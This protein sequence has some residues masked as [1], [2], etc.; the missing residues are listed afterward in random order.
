[1]CLFR[2]GSLLACMQDFVFFTVFFHD[3]KSFAAEQLWISFDLQCTWKTPSCGD[4]FICD[5]LVREESQCPFLSSPAAQLPSWSYLLLSVYSSIGSP[6]SAILQ[7]TYNWHSHARFGAPDPCKG[8][9]ILLRMWFLTSKPIHPSTRLTA[10]QVFWQPSE[11]SQANL[12][13]AHHNK[14]DEAQT[15]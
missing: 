12:S 4:S 7:G 5:H 15:C 3:L 11:N 2:L 13:N 1:M 14:L 9:L 10:D 8:E 6:G